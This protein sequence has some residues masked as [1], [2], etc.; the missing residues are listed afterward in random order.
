[1]RTRRGREDSAHGPDGTE[2]REALWHGLRAHV[3]ARLPFPVD[4][5]S[6][7]ADRCSFEAGADHAEM[8][9]LHLGMLDAEFEVVDSPALMTALDKL[10]GRYQR[11]VDHS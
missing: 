11:A 3:R 1:M 7:A 9:A 10:A 8:L 2:D 4:V 6:L 5:E